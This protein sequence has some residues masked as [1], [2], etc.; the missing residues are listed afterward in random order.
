VKPV[1]SS[2]ALLQSLLVFS[3][4]R[5]SALS[6]FFG[7]LPSTSTHDW[8]AAEGS[9]AG[10]EAEKTSPEGIGSRVVFLP[11]DPLWAFVYWQIDAGDRQQAL[12]GGAVD[13]CL[14]VADVTGLIGGAAHPHTL[15][16]IVVESNATEWYLPVPVSDR[17]YRVELGYRTGGAGGWISLAFSSVAHMPAV[18]P[19]ERSLDR[20]EP[21]S[22]AA[23]D[24]DAPGSEAG[25][26]GDGLHERLYLRGAAPWSGLRQGSEAFHAPGAGVWG[27]GRSDSGSGGVP[28]RWRPFWLEVDAA[29]IVYGATDPA[30]RLTIRGNPVPLSADGTFRQETA[31]PDGQQT[32]PIQACQADGVQR[33]NITMEFQR[34]TTLDKG[35]GRSEGRSEVT[36][37]WF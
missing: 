8:E 4:R 9:V 28:R 10:G 1:R 13:L 17:E 31:F 16:E 19:S 32:Y 26:A 11:R 21:F 2:V 35:N 22:M 33:R 27:S 5:L 18:H 24:P 12:A 30:A 20:Y 15:Q 36:P 34:R 14:R 7:I 3:G 6:D 23:P 25:S 37:E 29:L